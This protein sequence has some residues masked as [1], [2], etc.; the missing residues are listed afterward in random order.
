ML[1]VLGLIAITDLLC[2]VLPFPIIWNLNV[3]ERTK[4]SL[5]GVM[6]L[7]VFVVICPI[8]ELSKVQ[9]FANKEDVLYSI[10]PLASWTIVERG[11]T[12]IAACIPTTRSL[13]VKIFAKKRDPGA[14]PN[15]PLKANKLWT[16][17]N[18]DSSNHKLGFL[19]KFLS[20]GSQMD[21]SIEHSG[22]RDD[23]APPAR[24]TEDDCWREREATRGVN[25]AGMPLDLVDCAERGVGILR[26]TDVDVTTHGHTDSW[27]E[28]DHE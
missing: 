7:G 28:H 27:Y 2:V 23:Q 12:I 10:T 20:K 11:L 13:W 26:T 21:K 3:A 9:E 8:I 6:C 24:V 25:A 22:L 14:L 1:T 16:P 5:L 19:S 4:L 17:P 18:A 15:K